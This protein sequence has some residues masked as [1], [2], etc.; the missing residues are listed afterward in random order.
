MYFQNTKQKYIIIDPRNI[1][2]F[3]NF[4]SLKVIVYF[5]NNKRKNYFPSTDVDIGSTLF[6]RQCHSLLLP[7]REHIN[8]TIFETY[9]DP[10]HFDKKELQKMTSIERE[11][12]FALYF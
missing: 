8:V 9:T 4:P 3:S 5:H 11:R 2:F 7:P 12:D 6:S 10:G 1:Y